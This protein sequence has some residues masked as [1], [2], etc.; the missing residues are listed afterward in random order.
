MQIKYYI[1]NIALVDYFYDKF[2]K[3]GL[4]KIALSYKKD[5][6]I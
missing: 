6:E 1:I 2:I 5:E 4:L 3:I